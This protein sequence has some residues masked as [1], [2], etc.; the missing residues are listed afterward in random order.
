[1]KNVRLRDSMLLAAGIVL[2]GTCRPYDGMLLCLPVVCYLAWWMLFGKNRPTPVVLLRRS[3]IPLTLI[4]AAGAWM[5]YYDY[6]A[7]ANPATLPYTVNR[8]QYAVAPYFVW[9]SQHPEPFYRHKVM[10]EFYEHNEL[11][12]YKDIHR[13]SGFV[14]QT[15]V[16]V[17]SG[18]LFYAGI[19]LLVPL[20]MLRRV[21]LDRRIRFLV[22]C[23]LVLTAGQIIEI[24]LLPHYLAPF[25]AAF[26]AIGLQAMRHLWLWRPGNRPVGKTLVRLSVSLCVVMAGTRLYAKPLH[27]RFAEWPGA[28]WMNYW[29]GP[30]DFGAER[31]GITTG[32]EQQPG[33]QL[34]IVRYSSNHQP[35]DE[36]VYNA[37]DIDNSKIVWAREMD[38]TEN[39]ELIHYYKDRAVW[40]V[41]PDTKPATVSVYPVPVQNP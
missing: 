6:R 10:R 39:L 33:K 26:Y 20:I 9:Q 24:F 27:L 29:S 36:W 2:V 35:L 22:V 37:A 41:Q 1:M 7:F 28:R 32:L 5:G 31:A 25:T 18:F 34:V 23:V 38:E 11:D 13:L 4:I 16:K 14:P 3:V 15:L 40:L 19:V 21:F 12:A 17:M 30:G 8:T